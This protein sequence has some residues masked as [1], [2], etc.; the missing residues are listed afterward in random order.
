MAEQKGVRMKPELVELLVLAAQEGRTSALSKLYQEFH[1]PMKRF[2]LLRVGDV[3]IAEDLVQNV[4]IKVDR[5]L[6][7]LKDV[8]LFRSWLYRALRWEITDW[9]RAQ[10]KLSYQAPP[11]PEVQPAD[12]GLSDL[13]KLIEQLSEDERD[14]VELFYLNDLT[15]SETALALTLPEGTVKSRLSRARSKLKQLFEQSE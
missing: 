5:R 14:V 13:P 3:M 15:L 1:R 11:E 4:W 6:A 8:S 12:S 2:A 9:L 10:Q 7:H